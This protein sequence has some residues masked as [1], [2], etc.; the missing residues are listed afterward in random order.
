MFKINKLFFLFFK[1]Q[2][3][4]EQR[5]KKKKMLKIIQATLHYDVHTNPAV[6]STLVTTIDPNTYM[7]I[8]DNITGAIDLLH[9]VIVGKVTTAQPSPSSTIP[10]LADELYARSL[11]GSFDT[12]P[13]DRWTGDGVFA[14]SLFPTCDNKPR[15]LVSHDTSLCANATIVSAIEMIHM[16]RQA[17]FLAY[18]VHNWTQFVANG[19][20]RLFTRIF[21]QDVAK[22]LMA[23]QHKLR[24]LPVPEWRYTVSMYSNMFAP[25]TMLTTQVS[26]TNY[27]PVSPSYAPMSPSYAPT[28]P[29]YTPVS[30][31]YMPTSPS[32][33]PV[34]PS[35]MPTSPTY[36]PV[37]PTYAPTSP[38]YA[39]V[40][41]TYAPISPTY[42]PNQ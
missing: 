7:C 19:D 4:K 17:W 39:P 10:P 6:M 12:V 42:A 26:P 11:D 21:S 14:L 16:V 23:Y 1:S 31:S 3:R 13:V 33:T 9:S 30:P 20:D 36:T 35:Y 27:L 34:S 41:P 15:V 8:D 2:K 24:N 32:Y 5:K 38:T 28:S 37:S 29:S 25:F 22:R 40:S 18:R